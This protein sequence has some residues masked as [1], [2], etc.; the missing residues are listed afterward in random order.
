VRLVDLFESLIQ[1]RTLAATPNAGPLIPGSLRD[2]SVRA[3][4]V[5]EAAVRE[6]ERVAP[7]GRLSGGISHY[8]RRANAALA[9]EAA[10]AAGFA[11]DQAGGLPQELTRGG[12]LSSRV[13]VLLLAVP[14]PAEPVRQL[15][16]E[17]PSWLLDVGGVVQ[18][19]G[20]GDTDGLD[21]SHIEPL[22]AM[23]IRA[24]QAVLDVLN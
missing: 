13:L 14:E 18:L 24:L 21:A 6:L 11:L 10:R 8:D 20:H 17:S 5:L 9:I 16:R 15:A 4:I 23:T 22:H 12:T 19:R 3:T 1:A 7:A 2:V